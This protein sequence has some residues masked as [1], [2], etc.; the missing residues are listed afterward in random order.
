MAQGLSS[1]AIATNFSSP[2]VHSP[3]TSIIRSSTSWALIRA[4]RR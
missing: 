3:S 4:P 1:K 2:S